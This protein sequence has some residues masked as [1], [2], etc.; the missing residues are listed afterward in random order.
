MSPTGVASLLL[1]ALVI[2]YSSLGPD[3]WRDKI[4]FCLAVVGI[5]VGFNGSQLDRWTFDRLAGF[6]DFAKD[7]AGDAYIAR[8][9][10]SQLIGIFV[11]CLFVYV[12]LCLLPEWRW[13]KKKLGP[14]A[15]IAFPSGS[16]FRLNGRLWLCAF[17]LGLMAELANGWVGGLTTGFVDLLTRIETPL[18][19]LIFGVS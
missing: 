12:I 11:G 15:S 6:I 13:I 16:R 18:P 9:I 19:N 2:D 8:A 5:R 10:T 14:A 7:Q 1:L 3:S 4:A 17:F